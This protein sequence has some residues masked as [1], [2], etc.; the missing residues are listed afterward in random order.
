MPKLDGKKKVV[1]IVLALLGFAGIFLAAA[2]PQIGYIN[3][4]ILAI[5]LLA[6][7][8]LLIKNLNS[9]VGGYGAYLVATDKGLTLIDQIS[10]RFSAFWTEMSVWGMVLGFGVLAWPLMKGNLSKKTYLFGLFSIIVMLFVVLPYTAN[11]LEFINL[12]Q[13]QSAIQNH[14]ASAPSTGVPLFS[15]FVYGLTVI[16]GF[17]GYIIVLLLYNAWQILYGIAVF[18]SSVVAGNPQTSTLT[19]Q[20]P[21]AAP[22]IPGVDI[23]LYAG[24]IS[25][26]ILLAVHELSHG[27]LARIEKV[28]LKAVGMVLFGVI[29]IGAFVEPD[30]PQVMKLNPLRQTKIY[31]AGIASNF[32]AMLVFLVLM[33][34]VLTYFL[35]GIYSNTV[36]VKSTVP[37]YP[38]YN[39]LKP[40]MQILYWNGYKI[41]NLT[42]FVVAGAND[43]ANSTITVVTNNGSFA[44]KAI[45]AGS[46]S[47]R[48]LIGVN[49]YEPL[50]S[51]FSAQLIY[52][53]Y[54]VFALSFLLNFLVAVVNLLPVPLFDGWRIYKANVKNDRFTRF[55][56]ALIVISLLINVLPWFFFALVK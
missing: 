24:I 14:A 9:F 13:L 4:W 28:R 32:V 37:G 44:F 25:L 1:T 6:V 12:P 17:S 47:N 51:T 48:G 5:L 43:F 42:S 49:V 2:L 33:V 41:N 36:L 27:I 34:V 30:E 56:A 22:I 46:G 29:P 39:A 50:M 38:A 40:G 21:G 10:G 18:F 35:P 20:V 53:L 8:G 16:T 55:L 54:S 7:D 3:Q 11:G 52:F 45:A 26:I 15:Y 23:P 19:N 31:A